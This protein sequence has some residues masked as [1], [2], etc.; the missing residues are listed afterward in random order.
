MRIYLPKRQNVLR[1]MWSPGLTRGKQVQGFSGGGAERY[2]LCGLELLR[3][4][5]V[6]FSVVIPVSRQCKVLT[7]G[8]IG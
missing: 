6:G 4:A 1:A 2:L 8:D 5:G 3:A 7:L